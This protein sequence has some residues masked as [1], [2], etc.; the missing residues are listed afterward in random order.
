MEVKFLK[1]PTVYDLAYFPGDVT[2][3]DDDELVAKLFKNGIAEATKEDLP[4]GDP[5]PPPEGETG[6]GDPPPPPPEI[7]D[8]TSKAKAE[9]R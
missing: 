1:S 5:P 7:E 9:K 2:E 3:L 4:E 6:E 8:R